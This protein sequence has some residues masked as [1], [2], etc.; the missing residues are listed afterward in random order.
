MRDC[1]KCGAHVDG[2]WCQVCGEGKP[3]GVGIQAKRD[4]LCVNSERGQR[5]AN[6]GTLSMGTQSTG[7]SGKD[8]PDPR[9]C[10]M[11]FPPFKG[12]YHKGATPPPMGFQALKD[13]A[14]RI[15]PTQREPGEEG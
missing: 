13:L 14:H 4:W 15:A 9:Y 6:L 8:A 10:Y 5:C 12:R 7:A 2:Q 3:G 1:P 11:H